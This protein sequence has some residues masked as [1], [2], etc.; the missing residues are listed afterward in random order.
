MWSA[1]NDVEPSVHTEAVLNS[2][3]STQFQVYT[4][5]S[6]SIA[7]SSNYYFGVKNSQILTEKGQELV[8]DEDSVFYYSRSRVRDSLLSV[9]SN[10]KAKAA[11]FFS[12]SEF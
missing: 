4:G 5:V 10:G 1:L 11:R 6:D 2:E 3:K 12:E 7:M 9:A 8:D